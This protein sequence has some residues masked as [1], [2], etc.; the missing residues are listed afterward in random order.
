MRTLQCGSAPSDAGP[1]PVF[2][3]DIRDPPLACAGGQSFGAATTGE[4]DVIDRNLRLPQT[5]RATL[6]ADTHLP[7][8]L[9]GT[10]EGLYTRATRATFFAP[11]NLGGPVSADRHGRLMYGTIS[12]AGVATP[13][14]IASNLGDVIAITNHSGDYAYNIVGELRK[15]LELPP[16]V[17]LVLEE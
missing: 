5:M 12:A 3:A 8:G 4:V 16:R 13:L 1:P 15:G 6:A 17:A 7:F 10:I 9:V 2:S 14:R 11:I